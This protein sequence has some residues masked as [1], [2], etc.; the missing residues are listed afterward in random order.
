MISKLKILYL[1]TLCSENLFDYLFKTSKIKPT[2][3]IQKFHRL[4][5]NGLMGTKKVNVRTLSIIPLS[6]KS[7]K[8]ILWNRKKE[9]ENNVAYSYLPTINIAVLKKLIMFIGIF[10]KTLSWCMVTRN[11]VIICDI[12]STETSGGLLAAKLC[13]VRV[14]G[15]VTDIHLLSTIKALNKEINFKTKIAIKFVLFF[16]KKYDAYVLLTNQM[17]EIINKRKKPFVVIEGF[18]DKDM[19]TVYKQIRERNEKRVL[20]YAGGLYRNFGVKNLIEAFIQIPG[21]ELE[22]KLYGYGEME[23]DIHEY[24]KKDTRI[25]YLGM[26]PNRDVINAELEATLLINPRPSNLEITKY[27]FPSKILEYMMTG[28]PVVTCRLAGIPEEY[29]NHLYIFDKENTKG[30]KATLENLLAQTDK[31][32][33]AFGKEAKKFAFDEK[34]NIIQANKFLEMVN[35]SILIR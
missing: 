12:L 28:T 23:K 4:F 10:L 19:M 20:L 18:A 6:R 34:N 24:S 13:G 7:H 27:S 35:N 30:M 29:F 15:I 16:G 14:V 21:D 26:R 3:S 2:I 32:L 8:K 1:S 17:N 25:N 22:L 33:F 11:K 31:A 5:V 9:T